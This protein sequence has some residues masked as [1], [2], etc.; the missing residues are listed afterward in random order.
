MIFA[1][2]RLPMPTRRR[3]KLPRDAADSLPLR[4]SYQRRRLKNRHGRPARPRPAFP[5]AIIARLSPA[6]PLRRRAYHSL[7]LV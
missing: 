2:Y 6:P 7:S 3:Q 5:T 4:A 1:L